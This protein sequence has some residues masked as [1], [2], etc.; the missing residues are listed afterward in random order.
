VREREKKK[1]QQLNDQ[2]WFAHIIDDCAII[3]RHRK[4]NRPL[5][6][7]SD[8]SGFYYIYAQGI[9]EDTIAFTRKNS[10]LDTEEYANTISLFY[11][12]HLSPVPEEKSEE[13]EQRFLLIA[14]ITLQSPTMDVTDCLTTL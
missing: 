3:Y 1:M 13:V 9:L 11:L 5:V 10:W 8:D 6:I 4:I 12:E 14:N 7:S 2:D